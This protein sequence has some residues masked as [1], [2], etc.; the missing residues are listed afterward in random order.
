[1]KKQDRSYYIVEAGC[2]LW[3]AGEIDRSSAPVSLPQGMSEEEA[4]KLLEHFKN[5]EGITYYKHLIEEG[6]MRVVK[7]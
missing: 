7:L 6:L 5:K 3:G 2:I 1:M 4:N